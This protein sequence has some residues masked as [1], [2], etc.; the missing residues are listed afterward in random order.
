[1]TPLSGPRKAAK[2]ASPDEARFEGTRERHGGGQ[3]GSSSALMKEHD[4]V[5]PKQEASLVIWYY[6]NRGYRGEIVKPLKGKPAA[7]RREGSSVP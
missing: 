4:K 7:R 2:Q 3:R 5:R 6:G 1:M